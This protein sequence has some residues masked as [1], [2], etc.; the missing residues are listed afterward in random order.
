VHCALRKIVFDQSAAGQVRLD[1]PESASRQATRIPEFDLSGILNRDF[2]LAGIG[3]SPVPALIAQTMHQLHA[4]GLDV[5][6]F[7][8]IKSLSFS[9]FRIP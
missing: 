4:T 8:N 7:N 2:E 3:I 1:S 5:N 9:V 6:S